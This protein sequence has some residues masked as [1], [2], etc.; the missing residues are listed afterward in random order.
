MRTIEKAEKAI[1]ELLAQMWQAVASQ[2]SDSK[3]AIVN[4]DKVLANKVL[5]RERTIDNFELQIDK[6]CEQFIALQNPA[7]MN[8]RFVLSHLKMNSNLERIG[9]LAEGLANFVIKRQSLK[10][11]KDNYY[12]ETILSTVLRMLELAYQS[13]I[14]GDTSLSLKVVEMDKEVNSL[15]HKGM[16]ALSHDFADKKPKEIQE[17]LYTATLLRRVERIGDRCTNLAE[18]IIFHID[19]KELKHSK[20]IPLFETL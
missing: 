18:N 11:D 12:I 2:I 13:Y 6:Q 1:A 3:S 5:V 4:N 7:E 20:N 10:Y 14:K 8:L 17:L 9:D 16:T 19:A 15:Y